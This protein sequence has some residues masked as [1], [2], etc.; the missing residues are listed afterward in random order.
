MRALVLDNIEEN[1]SKERIIEK[2][3][4]RFEISCEDAEKYYA[5]FV[6]HS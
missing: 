4:K 5:Q 6:S 3:V 2:F 1:V